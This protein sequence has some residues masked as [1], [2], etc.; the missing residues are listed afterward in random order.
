M[1]GQA[2]WDEGAAVTKWLQPQLDLEGSGWSGTEGPSASS[3]S[4]SLAPEMVPNPF[5]HRKSPL[6]V[7]CLTERLSHACETL[8]GHGGLC[9]RSWIALCLRGD[10]GAG[11]TLH[12]DGGGVWHK[13]S[14]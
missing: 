10:H 1:V 2:V 14:A 4:P 9:C 5:T 7:P 8:Q 6:S 13:A 12:L 11:G 3:V